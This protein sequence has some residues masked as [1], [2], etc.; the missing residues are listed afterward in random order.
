[1]RD[2]DNAVKYFEKALESVAEDSQR[3]RMLDEVSLNPQCVNVG[4][5]TGSRKPSWGL[6][7]LP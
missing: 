7:A 6:D 3:I 4:W 5:L 2:Y 1:V